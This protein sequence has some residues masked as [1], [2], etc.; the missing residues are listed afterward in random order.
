MPDEREL[1]RKV[2][3]AFVA[4]SELGRGTIAV[5]RERTAQEATARFSEELRREREAEVSATKTA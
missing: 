1:I 5:S 2:V 4:Y 3:Q